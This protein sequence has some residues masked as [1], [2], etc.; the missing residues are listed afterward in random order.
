LHGFTWSDGAFER[1]REAYPCPSR[2]RFFVGWNFGEDRFVADHES[3]LVDAHL[4]APHPKRFGE[5]NGLGVF[6]LRNFDVRAFLG[7]CLPHVFAAGM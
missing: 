6:D 5:Q 2:G 3:M 4:C 1:G 7:N